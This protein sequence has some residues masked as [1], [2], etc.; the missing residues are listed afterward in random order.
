MTSLIRVKKTSLIQFDDDD[1]DL[2]IFRISRMAIG[3]LTIQKQ[4][5][6]SFGVRKDDE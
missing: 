5:L 1:L 4:T 2:G 3:T 6:E